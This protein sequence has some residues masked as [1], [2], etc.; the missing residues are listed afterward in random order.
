MKLDRKLM[1]YA[2]GA[3][4]AGFSSVD[5][6]DAAIVYSP[7][8]FPFAVD[9]TVDINFDQDATTQ[10]DFGVGHERDTAGNTSTDRVLLK[11]DDN[12]AN[13]EGY[14]IGDQNSFPVPL[15]AGTLIGPDSTYGSAFLN[16]GSDQIA[17]EDFNND[18]ALDDPI[19]TNFLADNVA[20]N[21]QYVGVRFRVNDTGDDRYGWIGIDITNADDLTGVVTGYAYDDSGAPIT[22]GQ[23]PE[24]AGLALLA[25]GAAGLLRRKRA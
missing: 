16:H 4:A 22:A 10:R 20:G 24:P 1:A 2:A 5:T 21:T 6:A 8:P 14:V 19:Q 13:N 17:D 25:L 12:G 23:V 18:N 11:E 15:A 3:A 9:G 7:G